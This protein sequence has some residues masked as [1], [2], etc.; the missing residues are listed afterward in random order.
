M[1]VDAY[2]KNPEKY[3]EELKNIDLVPYGN[4]Q[5][6]PGHPYY[7]EAKKYSETFNEEKAKFLAEAI[8]NGPS[9]D[10][11]F[12][13]LDLRLKELQA[14]LSPVFDEYMSEK[15]RDELELLSQQCSL[16]WLFDIVQT[17][18]G[19]DG[20]EWLIIGE[21]I[22]EDHSSDS[23]KEAARKESLDKALSQYAP[24]KY[25]WDSLLGVNEYDSSFVT[26]FIQGYLG[27]RRLFMSAYYERFGLDTPIENVYDFYIEKIRDSSSVEEESQL[28]WE[29][30]R[31]QFFEARE[32]RAAWVATMFKS[33]EEISL[34]DGE[35]RTL[36]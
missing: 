1:D 11:E 20:D 34:A 25:F 17:T 19:H 36:Q 30:W 27:C 7:E 16:M 22:G 8:P 6:G 10:A 29:K 31:K 21:H 9:T 12:R 5:I 14:K 28:Q 3:E 15:K 35:Q 26:E 2:N 24:F 33:Y 32:G 4:T 23:I 13:E 18:L